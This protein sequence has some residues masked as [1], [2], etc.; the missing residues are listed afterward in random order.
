MIPEHDS[1]YDVFSKGKKIKLQWPNGA[2]LAVTLAGNLEAWT[3]TPDPKLRRTRHAGGSN[4]ITAEEV[5]CKYDFRTA[6]EN[7]YGGRTGVWRIVRILEKYGLKASFNINGLAAIKY[8]DAVKKLHADG[9]EIVGHSYAEDIQLVLL[10]KEEERE[11][12]RTCVK[13]FQDLVGVRPY[14]WL[15]SGMRHTENT[16]ELLAGEGFLWHGDAVNDDVPYLVQ[17]KGKALVEIPYRNAISGLNDTGMY[18]R[19]ITARDLF[20]AFKDEFDMLYEES[21]AEPKMLTMAMH[22][23]MAFP[24]TGKVYE[25]SIKY[26][27]SFPEVWF[28]RR[29]DVVRWVLDNCLKR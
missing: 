16:L 21:L 12:I 8:P 14:G 6:S 5:R 13:I 10:S 7:D 28:A 4:P 18:R 27:K 9:H 23:Q 22:C 25:E 24:A 29:I 1:F 17:A 2:R 19:G 15:S 11:E 3:E 20:G 26:A